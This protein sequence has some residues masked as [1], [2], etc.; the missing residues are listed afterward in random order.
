MLYGIHHG[1]GK[2]VL[3][4]KAYLITDFKAVIILYTHTYVKHNLVYPKSCV[5]RNYALNYCGKNSFNQEDSA[6]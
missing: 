4:I 5:C 6:I 1:G 3:F 2:I